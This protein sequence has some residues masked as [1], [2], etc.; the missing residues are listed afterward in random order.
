MNSTNLSRLE[1]AIGGAAAAQR[2][3]DVSPDS[4]AAA[5]GFWR[6]AFEAHHLSPRMKELILLALHASPSSL[7]A[8]AVARH[9]AR[10][11]QAGASDADILDVLLSIVGLANHPLYF[12]VPI[13]MDELGGETPPLRADVQAIKDD[14]IKTRG[15]W[16][17]QRD[18][19]AALMPDYFKA[20]STLSMQP[21]K[22]GALAPKERE[23]V[24]IAIDCSV[25]HTHE[26]GLRLHL[27]NATKH[28]ATREEILETLHLCSLMGMESYILGCQALNAT[29]VYD[30][31][32]PCG[33]EANS[34]EKLGPPKS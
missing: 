30:A 12:A 2:I 29:G 17:P 24:Y 10:A 3:R 8:G 22:S 4:F 13:V 14:F 33:A 28:G 1:D 6:S 32:T 16:N 18:Q 34:A 19:L 21:W 5:A 27:R 31:G 23:L 11:R 26:G 25:T 9:V 15:V 20:F 7:N